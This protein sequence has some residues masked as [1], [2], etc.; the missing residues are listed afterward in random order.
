MLRFQV[1]LTLCEEADAPVPFSDST[2]VA[3][4]ALNVNLAEAVS[5]RSGREFHG[6][7]DTL[8]GGQAQRER[9]SGQG[10]L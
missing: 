7:V 1:R 10:E 3:P 4:V 9:N 2:A 5:T 6:V 8:S